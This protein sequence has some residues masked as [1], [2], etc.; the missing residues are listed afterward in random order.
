MRGTEQFVQQDETLGCLS[1]CRKLCSSSEKN[2]FL[3]NKGNS[4]KEV[5]AKLK[6]I[7]GFDDD[8]STGQYSLLVSLR[9]KGFLWGN[10]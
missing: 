10:W 8:R 5:F 7:L 1:L 4:Q 6:E 2:T 3:E 9:T